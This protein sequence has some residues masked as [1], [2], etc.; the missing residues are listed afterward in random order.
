M[1]WQAAVLMTVALEGC[2]PDQTKD[3]SAC[4]S[5]ANRFFQTYKAVDPDDPSSR[6]IIA[7]MATKGYDFTI[8]PADCDSRHALPT[9]PTCYIPDRWLGWLI[10]KFHRVL[11]SH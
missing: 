8:S 1:R 9:Q 10:D 5:E 2:V 3:V 7:C 6:Y 4:Q 11:K